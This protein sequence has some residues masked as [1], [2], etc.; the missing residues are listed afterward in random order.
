MFCLVLGCFLSLR[1]V[2]VRMAIQRLVER[3]VE[4]MQCSKV[5]E[6]KLHVLQL[7]LLT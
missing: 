7:H 4:R 5:E 3:L 2:S 6:K 1:L